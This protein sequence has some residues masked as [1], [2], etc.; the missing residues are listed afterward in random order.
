MVLGWE[1]GASAYGIG[2]MQRGPLSTDKQNIFLLFWNHSLNIILLWLS[3]LQSE[4]VAHSF[5]QADFILI[6]W[7]ITYFIKFFLFCFI[8]EIMFENKRVTEI[9]QFFFKQI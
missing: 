1:G 6:Y 3:T 4:S 9:V 5:F 2:D 7:N 8:P